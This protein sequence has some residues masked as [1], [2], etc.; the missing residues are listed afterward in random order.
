ML[1]AM[2]KRKISSSKK[3][4]AIWLVAGMACAFWAS[5]VASRPVVATTSSLKVTIASS[6]SL[7]I[8]PVNSSGT[9][10][11][12][13]PANNI[14]V[15]TD[16]Y[17]GYTL[18]IKAKV[19]NSNALTYKENDVT[20]AT[21]PSISSAVLASDYVSN[22]S[23]NNTWGYKPS[24]LYNSSTQTNDVNNSYLPAPTSSATQVVIA[25]TGVANNTADEYNIAIGA[26]VNGTTPPGSY[27]NTFVITATANPISYKISYDKGNTE[28]TVSGLPSEQSG[29][30]ADPTDN[31][32]G[33]MNV[34]LSSTVPTRVGMTFLGW[35]NVLPATNDGIDSCAGESTAPYAPGGVYT[36]D[37]TQSNE[38]ILYA[39][40]KQKC[41]PSGTTI[42][43]GN[44]T[45]ILCLQ[46]LG[47]SNKNTLITA[48]AEETTYTLIDSRDSRDYNIAKLKDG[49]VWMTENLNLAGG[50]AL[51]SS[52]TDVD[53]SYISTFVTSNNLTKTNDTIVLPD[54]SIYGFI[55][56][57]Y[58]YVYNSNNITVNQSDCA[59]A[60][61][62]N[63]YY[64][65]DAATLGSGR[66]ISTE[67]ADA[68]Y[69]I[70][71]KG[72]RLPRSRLTDAIDW[73][74]VSDFYALAHK[75]GLSSTTSISARGDDFYTQAGPGTIPNFLL[76]GYYANDVLLY[77]GGTSCYWSATSFR[78]DYAAHSLRV[79]SSFVNSAANY[80]RSTGGSVRC[81]I[82]PSS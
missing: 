25:Q 78:A 20:I 45:D 75:Y 2:R 64:S 65:W 9:F 36:L 72:W 17:S 13:S 49:K 33:A 38:V 50:T 28:D 47:G 37:A 77:G 51:S 27:S 66:S 23:L 76:V 10:A 43:T 24:V 19:A 69:S 41:N 34:I 59:D 81:L 22:T 46:D 16:N 79:E 5:G 62:C 48:M 63:S 30:I 53:S 8:N 71:P 57:N 3:G 29:T 15:W 68:P 31:T 39:M 82:A 54:S 4:K 80:N 61:P 44:A 7:D 55:T 26:R 56:E 40:W 11:S 18:G 58:A 35:C 1:W 74:I 60:K 32:S 42:G 70:C 21:I 73:Q 67:G 52:E 14:S 12:S 6:I